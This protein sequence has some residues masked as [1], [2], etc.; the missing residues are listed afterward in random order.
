MLFELWWGEAV[1][2][3][4]LPAPLLVRHQGIHV[5]DSHL[6]EKAS[7][8]AVTSVDK[9]GIQL[10]DMYPEEIMLCWFPGLWNSLFF[11]CSPCHYQCFTSAACSS[12][13]SVGMSSLSEWEWTQMFCYPRWWRDGSR[14]GLGVEVNNSECCLFLEN[15]LFG[16]ILNTTWNCFENC[17]QCLM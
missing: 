7:I 3:N 5:T 16:V 11:H 17:Q 13:N 4:E 8:G 15:Q 10:Q 6:W 14:R 9:E 1:K 12:N 2:M